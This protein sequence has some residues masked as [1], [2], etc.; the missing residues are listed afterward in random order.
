MRQKQNFEQSGKVLRILN[1]VMRFKIA[2]LK[3]PQQVVLQEK[4]CK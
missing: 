4:I 2:L 3:M 1:D